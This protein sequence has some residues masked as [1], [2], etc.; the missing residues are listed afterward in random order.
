M[1]RYIPS[2]TLSLISM[3][4]LTL[5]ACGG[6]GGGGSSASPSSAVGAN[7]A[8]ST[9]SVTTKV[10]DG[11]IQ[12][13][14][15]CVDSNSNGLCDAAETQAHTD[16]AGTAT[17]EVPSGSLAAARLIVVVGTD[18]TD[19]DSGGVKTAYSLTTP[20]GKLGVIS[21]L[22]TMV[23]TKI[24]VDK[25]GVQAAED[26]VKAQTG[27]TVSLFDDYVAKRASSPAHQKASD[28]VW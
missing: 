10:M 15:V 12:N 20:A 16:T 24:D 9:T 25:V 28:V 11:L 27:L 23:Q 22:T 13:A 5:T 19:A 3:A 21:P 2:L 18:A 8:G 4:V 1:K 26:Y 17:L 6:G 7:A 14:L